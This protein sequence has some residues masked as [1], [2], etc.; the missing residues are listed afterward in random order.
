ML[1]TD[2]KGAANCVMAE[3]TPG[4]EPLVEEWLTK[5]RID[6]KTKKAITTGVLLANGEG[7]CSP[8]ALQLL[9]S[10]CYVPRSAARDPYQEWE[11]LEYLE[12]A[13]F[14]SKNKWSHWRYSDDEDFS[15]GFWSKLTKPAGT[16]VTLAEISSWLDPN[17]L[18][19]NL[20][21]I[22]FEN[23]LDAALVALCR[24]GNDEAIRRLVSVLPEREESKTI[25]KKD[26]F[27]VFCALLHSRS[28]EAMKFYDSKG[29]LSDYAGE[30]RTTVKKLRSKYDL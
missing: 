18:S 27:I 21:R 19:A 23:H 1:Q 5:V 24:Y 12:P 6:P 10:L 4:V 29:L 17:D 30:H 3:G 7:K 2:N 13:E 14:Y 28:R 20:E 25:Q 9:V 16:G 8:E 22:Y 15:T 26:Y 11:Y